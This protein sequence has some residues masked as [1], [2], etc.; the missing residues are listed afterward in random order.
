MT[1]DLIRSERLRYSGSPF[2]RA[3]AIVFFTVYVVI[4]F[5][6]MALISFKP[7]TEI[8]AREVVLMPREATFQSSALFKILF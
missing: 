8:F 4:P 6:W 5:V 2:L 1:V 3:A 7:E